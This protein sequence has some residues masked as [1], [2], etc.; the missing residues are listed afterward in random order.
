MF[1]PHQNPGDLRVLQDEI[2]R[3]RI[4]RARKQTT[5]ERLTDVFELSNH[6]PQMIL[7]G[8]MHRL[9]TQDVEQGWREVCRWMDRLD[10]AREHK[11]YVREL[12]DEA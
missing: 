2:Y 7:S 10:G 11:F 1:N 5:E 9:A 3:E 4:L 12:P 8:A 6:Q